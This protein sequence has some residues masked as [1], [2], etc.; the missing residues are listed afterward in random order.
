MQSTIS[1]KDI[2]KFY[3]SAKDDMSDCP[4]TKAFLNNKKVND[5]C[6]N[7]AQVFINKGKGAEDNKAFYFYLL[8]KTEG[9]DGK[10]FKFLFE[11][12]ETITA[13]VDIFNPYIDSVQKIRSEKWHLLISVYAFLYA[14]YKNPDT[15]IN[16]VLKVSG[17]PLE[18]NVSNECDENKKCDEIKKERWNLATKKSYNCYSLRLWM[19]EAAGL[20]NIYDGD[21]QNEKFKEKNIQWKNIRWAK[22]ID[23][24]NKHNKN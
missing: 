10:E 14:A 2:I 18:G 11:D 6:N 8:K 9:S 7:L 13:K 5:E 17:A 22:V 21:I 19:A 3:S 1:I 24:I 4:I 16:D 23:K 12:G 20:D 15:P